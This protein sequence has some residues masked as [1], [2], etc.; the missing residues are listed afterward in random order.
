[1]KNTTMM[2]AVLTA[3]LGVNTVTA[4]SGYMELYAEAYLAR[5]TPAARI[6]VAAKV[7]DQGDEAAVD[8]A[9]TTIRANRYGVVGAVP[10][11]KT[12]I[13]QDVLDSLTAK[14]YRV[15]DLEAEMKA[16]RVHNTHLRRLLQALD[17]SVGSDVDFS[18]GSDV[19]FSVD[20]GGSVSADAG[21]PGVRVRLSDAEYET[22]DDAA[23][24]ARGDSGDTDDF[25]I[26]K[27]E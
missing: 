21:N 25:A 14:A 27:P 6:E 23:Q 1:M 24:A 19:D 3:A 22:D 2:A 20:A 16:L 15:T 5:A 4:S 13:D 9:V 11:G 12:I 17:A 7:L 8:A 10:L 26:S 18:V